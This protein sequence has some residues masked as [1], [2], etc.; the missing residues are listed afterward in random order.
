MICRRRQKYL[1]FTIS[2][3]APA[4][5]GGSKKVERKLQN[6]QRS[7]KGRGAMMESQQRES[8]GYLQKQSRTR[9]TKKVEKTSKS[10][11]KLQR[12]GCYD[13][14]TTKEASEKTKPGEPNENQT[15]SKNKTRN[16]TK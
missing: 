5:Q 12:S 1:P 14:I 13:G 7:C 2:P 4:K 3:M 16:T 15:K 10:A 6:L 11:K 9:K 8:P